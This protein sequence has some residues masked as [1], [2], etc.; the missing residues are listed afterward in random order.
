VHIG[1]TDTTTFDLDVDVIWSELLGFELQWKSARL[2]GEKVFISNCLTH[3]LLLESS[4]V[5]LAVDHETLERVWVAHIVPAV[6]LSRVA[7][8]SKKVKRSQF[9]HLR[10]YN[11]R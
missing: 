1:G 7:F 9:K 3:L 5:F 10:E 2:S 8:S 4:P 11:S 6:L